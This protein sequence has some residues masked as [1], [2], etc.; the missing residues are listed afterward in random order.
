MIYN[1]QLAPKAEKDIQLA[2][3]TEYL[4]AWF[5][6]AEQYKD[7]CCLHLKQKISKY[8]CLVCGRRYGNF[9]IT[10]CLVV[11]FLYFTNA[12]VQYFAL[13]AFL[14]DDFAGW[15]LQILTGLADE[16]P[17]YM[18]A[19]PRFPRVTLCD[20]EIRQLANLH[21]WTVQCVLPINLFNSKIF[22]FIWFWLVFLCV[23]SFSSFC[24]S[25]YASMYPIKRVEF[26][27]KYLILRKVISPRGD[28]RL[29]KKFVMSYLKFDGVYLLRVAAQNGTD[30][31]SGQLI[32]NLFV[33]YKQQYTESKQINGGE[34]V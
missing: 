19:S 25:V 31:L 30:I 29:V 6:L 4:D 3:M 23:T 11:K 16:N 13:N 9:Y 33:K 8:S 14:G 10:A 26:I 15:G 27:R 1:L 12:F 21:R 20:F 22:L 2:E 28:S 7:V 24:V 32:E 17:E 5:M 18:R 34:Y